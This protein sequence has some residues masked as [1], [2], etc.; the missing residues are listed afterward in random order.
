LPETE[1]KQFYIDFQKSKVMAPGTKLKFNSVYLSRELIAQLTLKLN[2]KNDEELISRMDKFTEDD[3]RE[4]L[5]GQEVSNSNT[6]RPGLAELKRRYQDLDEHLGLMTNE[7]YSNKP[8]E[9]SYFIPTGFIEVQLE[10][11]QTAFLKTSDLIQKK[12]SID[13]KAAKVSILKNVVLY[14]VEE[15]SKKN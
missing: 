14:F 6:D 9:K 15:L 3:W 5:L 2:P 11:N 4:V 1:Q 13:V 8:F 7:N 12:I 10:N